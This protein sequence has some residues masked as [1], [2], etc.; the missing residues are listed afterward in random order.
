MYSCEVKW[1]FGTYDA[2]EII[3]VLKLT[4]WDKNQDLAQG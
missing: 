2:C 4:E 3:S 1:I